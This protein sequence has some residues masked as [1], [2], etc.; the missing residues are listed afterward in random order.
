MANNTKSRTTLLQEQ[1]QV[2]GNTKY[3]RSIFVSLLDNSAQV[4]MQNV[5]FTVKLRSGYHDSV[6]IITVS[7]SNEE[8]KRDQTPVFLF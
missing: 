7:N 5:M 8:M 4:L 1:Q 3:Q 2:L 6:Y